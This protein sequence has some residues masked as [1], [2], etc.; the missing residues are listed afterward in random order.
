[1]GGLRIREVA[2]MED[3]ERKVDNGGKG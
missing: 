3:M 2:V 1:L